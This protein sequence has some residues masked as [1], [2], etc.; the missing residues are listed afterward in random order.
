MR[1]AFS[2]FLIIWAW[3]MP[4]AHT[5]EPLDKEVQSLK[6]DVDALTQLLENLQSVVEGQQERIQ[7]LEN[8]NTAL[9]RETK[10]PVVERPAQPRPPEPAPAAM[11]SRISQTLNPDIGVVV[12]ILGALSE[13][14]EDE[15]G[16]DK[17]SVRELE[18]TIGHDIDPYTR[19]D[20]TITFSD[21][22]DV[23]IEEAY[24]TFLELPGQLQVRAGRMRPK[25]GKASAVH[26]DQL[27]TVDEP[28]VVQRY[29]GAEGLFRT[30]VEVSRYLP[31]FAGPLTQEVTVG[32]L[33]GGIGEG[34]SLFGDTRRHPTYYA[35]LKNS[36]DLSPSTNLELGGTYLLGSSGADDRRDVQAF[37]ADLTLRHHFTSVRT[38]KWQSELYAQKRDDVIS[39]NDDPI[40][41]YSLL[42]FRVSRRWG[43][44]ARYDW[45]ELVLADPMW[46]D[47]KEKAYSAY[48]TF[49]QSEFARLRLQYQL[50]ESASGARDNRF[51]LQGTFAVGV[52]KHKL[53]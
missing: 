3:V 32:I 5:Q 49:F 51:F 29:L 26:R 21:T 2:S 45:V 52:H 33:E 8:E 25:I 10:P 22:E 23:E 4:L 53:Q 20:S 7:A 44:G 47:D 11:G 50:V 27:D 17:F 34:G 28:L 37:G 15:E 9:L 48:I 14:Q 19:F 46:P 6:E 38:L 16:N 43:F 12:D 18:L 13:S 41:F 35:H 40:G 31:Q 39:T 24:V 30:G 36:W 42:D 1:C